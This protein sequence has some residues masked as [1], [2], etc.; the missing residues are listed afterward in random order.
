MSFICTCTRF[1]KKSEK[2]SVIIKEL[3]LNIV[4]LNIQGQSISIK[5]CQGKR[6]HDKTGRLIPALSKIMGQLRLKYNFPS[7]HV[8]SRNYMSPL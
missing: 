7:S 8:Q 6:S 2:L 4:K 5:S 3:S 1:R